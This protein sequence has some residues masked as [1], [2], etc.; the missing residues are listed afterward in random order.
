MFDGRCFNFIQFFTYLCAELK[1][2]RPITEAAWIKNKNNTII[3][4]RTPVPPFP[5]KHTHTEGRK[6]INQSRTFK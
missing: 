1:G 6:R 5:K 2:Q 3:T 4:N